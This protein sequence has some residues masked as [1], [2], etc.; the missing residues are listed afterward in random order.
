MSYMKLSRVLFLILYYIPWNQH[1]L[2]LGTYFFLNY[3]CHRLAQMFELW[4]RTYDQFCEDRKLKNQV[5][6]MGR[7]L[8]DPVEYGKTFADKILLQEYTKP[9]E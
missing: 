3:F 6:L 9:E 8:S 4:L 2:L 5:D 7:G 1:H